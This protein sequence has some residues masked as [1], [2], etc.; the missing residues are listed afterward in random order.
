MEPTL[1]TL[2]GRTTSDI[3]TLHYLGQRR[4]LRRPG[5]IIEGLARWERRFPGA[6]F[7]SQDDPVLEGVGKGAIPLVTFPTLYPGQG[8]RG[9]SE[10]TW[11]HQTGTPA[12]LLPLESAWS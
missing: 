4:A 9:P 7:G 11:R 8:V 12:Y 1:A 10:T 6:E 5:V 2:G 3:G